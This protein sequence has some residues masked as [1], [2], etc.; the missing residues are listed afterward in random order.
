MNPIELFYQN[1]TVL[2]TGGNGF[3]GS[4]LVEKLLRCFDVKRIFLL[5]RAK[6]NENVEQRS[7]L[8][9]EKHVK[10]KFMLISYLE[11]ADMID[12]VDGRLNF[13]SKFRF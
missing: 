12:L 6:N 7:K 4:V 10:Y 11:L 8:F 1:S 13:I 9:F 3:L 2:V 5:L